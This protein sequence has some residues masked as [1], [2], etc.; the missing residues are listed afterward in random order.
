[1]VNQLSQNCTQYNV[2]NPSWVILY[3]NIVPRYPRIAISPTLSQLNMA[4]LQPAHSSAV[5]DLEKGEDGEDISSIRTASSSTQHEEDHDSKPQ[6]QPMAMEN[7]LKAYSNGV[8]EP[9]NEDYEMARTSTR[10]SWGDAARVVTR[11][12]TK[13]SW[14]DPGPPPDGG[15]LAWTQVA[16]GHLAIMNT[17]SVPFGPAK[18]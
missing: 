17:W 13:S 7:N 4:N 10:R 11:M 2:S 16:M 3:V 9:R 8:L 12:S 1:M 14:K 5:I 18:E 6:A 15:L